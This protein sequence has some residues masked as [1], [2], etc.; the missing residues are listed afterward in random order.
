MVV[1]MD[2]NT[3][4]KNSNFTTRMRREGLKDQLSQKPENA[5]VNSFFRGT[6][7]I[8]GIFLSRTLVQLGGAYQSFSASPGDH[9][10][11]WIDI[12][13][14]AALGN[15]NPITLPRQPRRLQIKIPST[16]KKF[17]EIYQQHIKR[18]KLDKRA[19][20]LRET[21]HIPLTP[22]QVKEFEMIDNQMVIGMK[23]AD[24]GCRKLNMGG[25]QWT[26]K[27]SETNDTINACRMIIKKE[28][29]W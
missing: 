27:F 4:I 26:P 13:T 7:I 16:V 12:C 15:H 17:N 25:I 2:A 11:I 20:C 6:E 5:A 9:R 22:Q 1:M 24:K 23:L 18:H 10:G 19:R 3:N 28:Q 29:R 8:D 21:A 14:H